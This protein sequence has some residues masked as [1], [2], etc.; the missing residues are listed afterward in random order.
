MAGKRK[1]RPLAQRKRI[2][3]GVSR[4]Y[5]ETYEPYVP[6]RKRCTICKALKDKDAFYLRRR[7]LKSG[8]VSEILESECRACLAGARKKMRQE[9]RDQGIDVATREKPYISKWRASLSLRRKKEIHEQQREWAAV[10]RR[11]EG[12]PANGKRGGGQLPGAGATLPTEPIIAL[13]E[14]EL[15]LEES[16]SNQYASKGIGRLADQ[17]GVA[18][19]RIYGLLHG[20]YEKV[21]LSTVDRLLHGLGLP[22]MLPILYPED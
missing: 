5:A 9:L 2:A 12:R 1:K 10:R 17:S 22:H 6:G 21:A 7:K 16:G 4:R 15:N 13:L 3:T 18:Q 14:D 11:K 19:R 8:L 20:E